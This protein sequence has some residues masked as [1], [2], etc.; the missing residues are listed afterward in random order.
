MAFFIA[1]DLRLAVDGVLR[2]CVGFGGR[3]VV[4]GGGGGGGGGGGSGARSNGD[5]TCPVVGVTGV[6]CPRAKELTVF[7]TAGASGLT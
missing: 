5:D 3:V 7:V 4:V 2:V 6:C 1:V